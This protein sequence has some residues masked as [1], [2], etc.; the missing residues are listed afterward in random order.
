MSN[1][2]NGNYSELLRDRTEILFNGMSFD[3]IEQVIVNDYTWMHVK[4]INPK[5][6]W[7][8]RDANGKAFAVDFSHRNR[9]M[10]YNKNGYLFDL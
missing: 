9:K 5:T 3:D 6:V 7:I 8:R 4:H 10:S 2:T 1:E